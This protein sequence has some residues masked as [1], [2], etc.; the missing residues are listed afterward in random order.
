MQN[1]L[2]DDPDILIDKLL[3]LKNEGY[4]FRGHANAIWYPTPS[5]FRSAGQRYLTNKYPIKDNIYNWY[6]SNEVK[7]IVE[8]WTKVKIDKLIPPGI[9]RIFD[10]YAFILKYNYCLNKFVIKNP[11]AAF[12]PNDLT[13][14]I[15]Q[16]DWSSEQTF[17]DFI[18]NTM[19]TWLSIYNLDGSLISKGIPYE[20]L[21]IVEESFP[22]H[23]GLPTAAL[24]FS[25]NPLISLYFAL[26]KNYSCF[27]SVYGYKQ[28]ETNDAPSIIIENKNHKN[29]RAIK[30]QGCFVYF[31]KPCSHYVH[32]NKYP[33]L[34]DYDRDMQYGICDQYS[35]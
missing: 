28:L 10:L 29:T 12:T 18:S 11:D 22:Q 35:N 23:Y 34:I 1:Y 20:E 4:V 9:R 33:S 13:V 5:V 21:T 27:F 26:Q 31:T 15:P 30:Q 14:I 25:K 17:I 24:D 19:H 7:K 3:S 6:F 32:K 8:L 2:I 16:R